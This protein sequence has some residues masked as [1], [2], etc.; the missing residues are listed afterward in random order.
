MTILHW[1]LVN[2]NE[3]NERENREYLSS[4]HETSNTVYIQS[5]TA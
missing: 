3:L 1:F 2:K 4:S 5:F